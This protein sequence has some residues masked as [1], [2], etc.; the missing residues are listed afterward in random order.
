MRAT[1]IIRHLG[2]RML[3]SYG[4]ARCPVHEDRQPSLSIRDAAGPK[5]RAAIH[6]RP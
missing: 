2:G 5:G 6:P 3:A 4:L 1:D